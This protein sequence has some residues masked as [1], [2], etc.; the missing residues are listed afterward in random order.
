LIRKQKMR[1]QYHIT[2]GGMTAD[3]SSLT[4]SGLPVALC[5]DLRLNQLNTA[6]IRL[7]LV[8]SDTVKVGDDVE[9]KVG[10]ERAE[11]VFSGIV[12]ELQVQAGE[13]VIRAVSAMQMLTRMRVDKVYA[14]EKAGDIVR[15]LA[16]IADVGTGSIESGL[17][18]PFYAVGADRHLLDHV[19]VLGRRDGFDAYADASDKLVFA[20]WSAALLPVELRYGAEVLDFHSE[21][22][23]GRVDGV[24]VYGESPASLGE[25]DKAYSW[26][27]KSEVKGNA[28]SGSGNVLRVADPSIRNQDAAGSAAEKL[29]AAMQTETSGWVHALGNAALTLGGTL[30]LSDV[31]EGGPSGNLKITGV[32]H[33][34]DKV[35]G[36]VTTVFWTGE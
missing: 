36:F 3:S 26:L 7:G 17:T 24:E 15:D 5:V 6:V 31:P 27:T 35:K 30:K 25:G 8:P 14:E 21:T 13:Y 16:G 1:P 9:I 19:L 2:A 34:L 32:R 23:T 29:L 20:A 4:T 10:A 22:E 33:R 11:T 18:Y 28:G 12:S